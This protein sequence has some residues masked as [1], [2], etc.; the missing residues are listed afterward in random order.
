MKD[1]Y[2]AII[3]RSLL[4]VVVF[5]FLL[6]ISFG[7]VTKSKNY[8]T[9][10]NGVK[11][12]EAAHMVM[13][14]DSKVNSIEYR[15]VSSM[16]EAALY[17]SETPISFDGQMT[18]YKSNCVGCSGKVACP[19]RQDVSND[20]IYYEDATYGKIRI[21]AADPNIPCGTI[22]RVTNVTFTNDEIIGI[23]LDRG[24]AIKGNIMDFLVGLNDDMNIVG[25]QK[26][27][28]YEILRWGF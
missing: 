26:A 14:Y 12:I 19:P 6:T 4:V 15:H 17:G 3:S 22:V 23:V 13:S 5:I 9:N 28:H 25:R 11:S 18:A 21:L 10:V 8:V 16:E 1:F 27:A 2:K 24:G 20:N 7:T